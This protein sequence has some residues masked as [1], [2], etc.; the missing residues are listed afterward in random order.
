MQTV[1]G[2][3]GWVRQSVVTYFDD[4]T[5][6]EKTWLTT[7]TLINLYLFYAWNDSLMGLAAS[8][9]GMMTVVLVAKGRIS[10]YYFGMVNVSL[11]AYIAWQSQFYGEV[12][13]NAL[14]FL[15]MQFI[16]LYLWNRN[17]DED[18]AD[19]VQVAMLD[20]RKRLL[21]L[22]GAVIAIAGY[23]VFLQHLGGSLPFFDSTSTVLSVIAQLLMVMRVME[24]WLAWITIDIVSIYMWAFDYTQGGDEVSM[25]VMW[26][27]YLVNAVYGLYNW[28]NLQQDQ[29]VTRI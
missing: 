21:L 20:N 22:V 18:R 12:M 29:G 19:T 3:A 4:W 16:G 7:F 8:L 27:A 15:P 10:N 25:I 9:T 2:Y 24:Q 17:Q 13:L 11:Y 26:T 28:Y 5:L 14:Y 23:G 6:W 1:I